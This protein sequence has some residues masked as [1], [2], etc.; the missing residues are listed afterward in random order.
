ML[1]L[2]RNGALKEILVIIP[3]NGTQATILIGTERTQ[4]QKIYQ[5]GSKKK[6][7]HRKQHSIFRL[8]Y[9]GTEIG[10]IPS[11]E[12][13]ARTGDCGACGSRWPVRQ[14]FGC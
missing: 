10:I 7:V 6:L 8:L 1:L 14:P 5:E 4:M 2:I 11:E 13:D 9:A 12:T 3:R